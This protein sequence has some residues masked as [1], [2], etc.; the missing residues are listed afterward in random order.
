[1]Q[2]IVNTC[3]PTMTDPQQIV[4][5]QPTF[6]LSSFRPEPNPFIYESHV[7]S[8]TSVSQE[9]AKWSNMT[10]YEYFP[11]IRSIVGKRNIIFFSVSILDF[12][13]RY[14]S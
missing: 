4:H 7:F 12:G 13:F 1:M 5:N 11:A 2:E 3:R 14:H 10:S 9:L 8:L 6:G